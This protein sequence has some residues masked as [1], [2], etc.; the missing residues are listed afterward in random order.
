LW[1]QS[2]PITARTQAYATP[3]G[4]GNISRMA[5]DRDYGIALLPE[6]SHQ[7]PL[8]RAQLRGRTVGA[9]LTFLGGLFAAVYWGQPGGNRLAAIVAALVLVVGLCWVI[10]TILQN[11]KAPE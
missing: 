7:P 6:R 2:Y 9:G 10:V 11:V 4:C 1:Q 5:K 3:T 8:T